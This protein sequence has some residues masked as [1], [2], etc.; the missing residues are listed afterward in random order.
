MELRCRELE[1]LLWDYGQNVQEE[2]TF[3]EKNEV[4]VEIPEKLPDTIHQDSMWQEYGSRCIGC[5]RCNLSV[6]HVPVL[7]CRI[8]FIKTIQRLE[9]AVVY[10]FLSGEWIF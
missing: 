6:P 5:G 1:E 4:H 2:P 10:G 7:L 3:V 9:S 8:F